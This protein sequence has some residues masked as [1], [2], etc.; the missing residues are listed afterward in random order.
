MNGRDLLAAELFVRTALK[1]E[2]NPAV[3]SGAR[4]VG[5]GIKDI[6]SAAYKGTD[7]ATSAVG[8]AAKEILRETPRLGSAVNTAVRAAPWVGGAYVASEAEKKVGSP[9][10]NFVRKQVYMHKLRQARRKATWNQ[11][12]GVMY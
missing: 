2:A 10:R 11:Q 1:K 8:G 9:V 6:L 4:G 3:V 5:R 12:R 7:A